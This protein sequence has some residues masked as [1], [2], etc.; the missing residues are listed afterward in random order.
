V[1]LSGTRYLPDA[2]AAK[3]RDYVSGG[4]ALIGDDWPGVY[5]EFGLSAGIF[6]RCSV[7]F[8]L[9]RR[10]RILMNGANPAIGFRLLQ[11]RKN[12]ALRKLSVSGIQNIPC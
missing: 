3:L 12:P 2:V 8:P 9:K 11:V 6:L 10:R 1:I 7:S 5:N 4:G